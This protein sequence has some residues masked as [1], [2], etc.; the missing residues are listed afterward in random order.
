MAPA[1]PIFACTLHRR[2][3]LHQCP[4]CRQPVHARQQRAASLFP[5]AQ[6]ASLHPAQ[7][8]TTIRAGAH[9]KLQAACAARLDLVDLAAHGQSSPVEH[10][11]PMLQRLLVMQHKLLQLLQPHGPTQTISMGRPVAVAAYFLDLHL[12]AGLL[13]ASWP[14]ARP[15][16]QAWAGADPVDQHLDHQR[17][18]AQARRLIPRDGCGDAG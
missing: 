1:A 5:R 11:Q 9:W 14:H 7:C 15:L 12:L 3:L 4:Q 18:Q 2:L 13:L 16:A 17:Q 8:R 6:D 10:E